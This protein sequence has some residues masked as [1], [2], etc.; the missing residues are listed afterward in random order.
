MISNFASRFVPSKDM[1]VGNR[2]IARLGKRIYK[3]CLWRKNRRTITRACAIG[4]FFAFIPTPFQMVFAA[5][6]AV[7]FNAYLPLSV[8]LV[9]IT[10][11]LTMP[12]I[13]Y[14]AYRLGE[15]IIG[16]NVHSLSPLSPENAGS[17]LVSLFV[18]SFFIAIS[19]S[20]FAFL[21]THLAWRFF[22]G[23]RWKNRHAA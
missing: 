5:I 2:A 3:P 18:G 7:F 21:S 20:I 11:P 23:R 12:P 6:A 16:S 10:N 13:F 17:S 4:L 22:I 15:V 1:I 8:G 19:F 9:W 14:L